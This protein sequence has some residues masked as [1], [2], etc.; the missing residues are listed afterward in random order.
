[1]PYNGS[2]TFSPDPTSYPAVAG[3]VILASKFNA[4]VSDIASGLSTALTRDGQSAATAD[5]SLG[6]FKLRNLAAATVGSD[7]VN[8]AQ[9]DAK[10]APLASPTFT[11][12]LTGVTGAFTT[13]LSDNYTSTGLMDFRVAGTSRARISTNGN[14]RFDSAYLSLTSSTNTVLELHKTGAAA[15]AW[16]IETGGHLRLAV[17]D[18]SGNIVTYNQTVHNSGSSWVGN[19]FVSTGALGFGIH[20]VY[21]A[22]AGTA[23]TRYS[24]GGL[25]WWI[26]QVDGA[27]ALRIGKGALAEPATNAFF[28]FASTGFN[29]APGQDGALSLGL[30]SRRFTVVYAT[31]GTIQTSDARLKRDVEDIPQGLSFIQSL[32]PVSYRWNDSKSQLHYGFI[33]QEVEPHI[34]S[35]AALVA[36]G[37][38]MGMNYAELT[39]PLV[40]AV[41]ELA[42]EVASLRA[43]LQVFEDAQ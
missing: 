2:G 24:Q 3:Q 32:R 35:D 37:E 25:E 26:G 4:I 33:A 27:D 29:P 21:K 9:A 43:R 19:G 12:T 1:M 16:N 38:V 6:G 11:G 31:N 42:A 28:E 7:A 5:I 18:G 30:I 39:A 15:Y 36:R 13:V 20:G 34:P 41:Q 10:Y 14:V 8:L 23:A 22:A 17:S 40:R